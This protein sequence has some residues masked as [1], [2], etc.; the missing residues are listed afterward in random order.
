[1]EWNSAISNHPDLTKA[2]ASC[3]ETLEMTSEQPPDV[4]FVFASPHYGDS[5]RGIGAV[6]RERFPQVNVLGT[7]G[8]GIVGGG[9]EV[10]RGPALSLTAA[11]L[12]GVDITPF[13][14]DSER[15]Q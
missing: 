7:G 14:V 11:S 4:I 3:I 13:H 9:H 6:L 5:Q 8:S 12:P 10:E 1:M 15:L 2:L